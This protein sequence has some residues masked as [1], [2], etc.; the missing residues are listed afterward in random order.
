MTTPSGRPG[1]NAIERFGIT[2]DD[3]T[4][5]DLRNRTQEVITGILKERYVGNPGSG[6]SIFTSTTG[7]L[8]E[9]FK[10]LP[11]I[12]GTTS[13][14]VRILA[15]VAGRLLGV[16][17]ASIVS[18][19]TNEERVTS[20]IM[21]L[22]KV[23]LLGEI[24]ELLTGIEDGDPND[25][26]TWARNLL[27]RDSPIDAL[28]LYGQI[29]SAL[30]GPL[31]I[32]LFTDQKLTLLREGGF[33][34]PITIVEGSGYTHDATDGVP[35]SDP[36]GCARV[37]C[38]GQWHV[39]SSPL[40]KVAPGWT[41]TTP[42]QVK[43]ES[44]AAAANSNAVRIELVPY[45][46]TTPGAAVWMASDESPAGTVDWDDLNAWGQYVVPA[47]GVTDV[48]VL[49]VVTPDATAGVVKFDNVD[50]L[51]IQKIP[52][53]FTKD[54]P[55]DLASL[56]NFIQTWVHSALTAL[57]ITPSGVL[58]DDI[59]DLSDEIEFIQTRAEQ[60]VA[61]AAAALANLGALA[62]DLLHDPAAVLG[63]LTTGMVTGLDGALT[64]LNNANQQL[65]DAIISALRRIPV[66]GGGLADI[67]A[68]LGD[69]SDT[70]N[71][72]WDGIFR[73]TGSTGKTA[74]D[75]QTAAESISQAVLV[76]QDSV[77]TLANIANAPKNVPYWVSPNPFE[78][79]SFPRSQVQ[80]VLYVNTPTGTG[81][82]GDTAH[83][84]S[85][86]RGNYT[87]AT[88]A[89]GA[90][91]LIAI[92]TTQDRIYN[93]VG[94]ITNGDVPPATVLMGLYRIDPATGLATLEYNFGNVSTVM[95]S[96]GGLADF[97]ANTA[98]DIIAAEG[99]LWGVG[100][101]PIGGTLAIAYCQKNTIANVSGI[102]PSFASSQAPGSSSLPASIADASLAD[103]TFRFWAG[104][105]QAVPEDTSPITL[106]E[107]F[108]VANTDTWTS[109]SW[110]QFINKTNADLGTAYQVYL[111]I[112]S[113]RIYVDSRTIT[114]SMNIF[115]TAMHRRAL[116][117]FN[118]ASEITIGS[119]WD[120]GT[121]DKTTTRAYVRCRSNAAGGV[122]MHLD[123]N[124]TNATRLRIATVAGP[125]EI[126][127][128][129]ATVTGLAANVGDKF[130]IECTDGNVYTCYRNDVAI[131]GA[132]WTD[133]T[134]IVPQAK[135][136]KSVGCGVGRYRAST[137]GTIYD[138]AMID[139]WTG[140]D[141]AA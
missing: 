31:P 39:Q 69:L 5:P 36:L 52:Q 92:R 88:I 24:I 133:S 126:G 48:A 132:T 25:L 119:G 109:P 73:T 21:A 14:P 60:G 27:N 87:A 70:R 94:F 78:D 72:L 34:E 55:E 83:S 2:G 113:G 96:G 8:A 67:L 23:P 123:N 108:N 95:P 49:T 59:L 121:Y 43:Y 117:T 116:N 135:A 16:D 100:V 107:T 85:I 134:N 53:A 71:R 40:I 6:K 86:S 57:G 99:D 101:L 105:G 56:L 13:L 3:G 74:A 82:S 122:A 125:N 91:T 139:Y 84:H 111:G 30:L 137:F 10:G 118:Q 140:Y 80:P 35:G 17:P 97:R 41:L 112:N 130:R 114:L 32:G 65:I 9:V 12:P 141:L 11:A 28:K 64:F 15:A 90:F 26:A 127:T 77:I 54:L 29:R 104:V 42:A 22:E 98:Y 18:G 106:V 110:N 138:T 1:F 45:N 115:A 63:N 7:P 37:E 33:D 20:V 136:Y 58:L 81:G 129:R 68:E 50:V 51:A 103:T 62:D 19:S 131:P 102:F 76:A 47:T 89:D 61:D 44:V 75:V 93:S 79:V 128:V 4:I 120:T 46:G 66:I 38:D 124:G